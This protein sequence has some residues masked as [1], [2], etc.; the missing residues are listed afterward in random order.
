MARELADSAK[1]EVRY[2]AVW[3]GSFE[4]LAKVLPKETAQAIEETVKAGSGLVVTGGEGSFHGG[5]GRAAVM[6][7]TALNPVLPA[8]TLGREDLVYPPHQADD[9]LQTR[10][11]FTTIAPVA[12]EFASATGFSPQSLELLQHYGVPGFNQV[13]T[14]L[15][16]KTQLSIAGLP[17]LITGT[18]GAGRTVAFTGFTP[19]ASDASTEPLD[20]YLMDEPQVRAYFSVFADLMA[21]VLPAQQPPA[22]QLLAAHEKPLFQTLKEQPATELAVTKIDAPAGPGGAARLRVRIANR[23]RLRTPGA[24]TD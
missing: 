14:K 7:A 22:P 5:N 12:S 4:Y 13:A 19:E 21:D 10:H 3:L 8:D 6:E 18:Y 2:D 16:S 23:G 15:G 11:T 1:L 20:Q 17:L 9:T 24:H